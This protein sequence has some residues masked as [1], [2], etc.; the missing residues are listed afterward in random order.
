MSRRCEVTGARYLAG[1]KVS[2]S[3]RKS[4]KRSQTNLQTKRVWVP[5]ESR[6]V[7]VRLTT[8]ALRTL[9]RIGLRRAMAKYVGA[10]S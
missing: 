5:E 10:S 2:H 4:K 8:R 7:T 1:N 9:D 3:N 6:F